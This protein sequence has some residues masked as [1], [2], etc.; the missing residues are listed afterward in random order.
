MISSWRPSP[1]GGTAIR[2]RTGYRR[3]ASRWSRIDAWIMPQLLFM[4]SF[5][6]RIIPAEGGLSRSTARPLAIKAR[7]RDRAPAQGW[8][9]QAGVQFLCDEML[10]GLGRWRQAAG[11]DHPDPDNR[12]SIRGGSRK[13]DDVEEDVNY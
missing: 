8:R 2:T 5:R 3:S 9:R 6:N 10:R 4:N 7:R 1:F 13:R 11:Q 12:G